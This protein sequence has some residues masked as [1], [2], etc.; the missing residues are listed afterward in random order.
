MAPL[1]FRESWLGHHNPFSFSSESF[2]LR[3]SAFSIRSKRASLEGRV[4]ALCD[5]EQLAPEVP[6]DDPKT[7]WSQRRGGD[8]EVMDIATEFACCNDVVLL[9]TPHWRKDDL[10]VAGCGVAVARERNLSVGAWSTRKPTEFRV[11]PPASETQ[12]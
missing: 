7:A 6:P 11:I 2:F 5:T 9:S 3:G 1:L 4:T 12:G 8:V 10:H